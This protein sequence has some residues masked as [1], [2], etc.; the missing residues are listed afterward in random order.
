MHVQASNLL[1]IQTPGEIPEGYIPYGNRFLV[2]TDC[3]LPEGLVRYNAK[4]SSS[5]IQY[6]V[7]A[8]VRAAI[9]ALHYPHCVLTGFGAL[10]LYGLPFFA[11][12]C[13]TVLMHPSASCARQAGP[14]QPRIFRGSLPRA[15]CWKVGCLSQDVFVASPAMATVQALKLVRQGK[16]RWPV[17]TAP[18]VTEEFTRAVQLV[19]ATRRHLG[20]DPAE[21]LHASHQHLE[22]RWMNRVVAASS[23]LADSPKETEM[24]LVARQIADK[25]DLF[26]GQQVVVR[27]N[28][29]IVTTFDLTLENSDTGQKI[30][31]MYD[32]QHHWERHQR[33][34]DAWINL[35]VTLEDWVPLR[36]AADAL[37]SMYHQL[38]ALMDKGFGSHAIAR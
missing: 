27:R 19:D 26:L 11:D 7:P 37:G 2:P 31:I 18:G 16:A 12:S 29:R 36:Y 8:A 14:M 35:E 10:A 20:T 13:D 24:R 22:S 30:G 4:H 17:T 28:N 15:Y 3:L 6:H 1:R 25:F 21:I 23:G 5:G 34:K 33:Q 9:H 38:E 32:G